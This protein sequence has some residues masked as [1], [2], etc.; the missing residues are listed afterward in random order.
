MGALS[1]Q[2]PPREAQYP[3]ALIP[4]AAR[5]PSLPRQVSGHRDMRWEG[6]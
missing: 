2:A 4:K 3:A 1:T 6:I 5:R